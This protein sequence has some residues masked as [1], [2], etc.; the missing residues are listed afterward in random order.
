MLGHWFRLRALN[1]QN[2]NITV[3]LTARYWK[4]NSSGALVYS[5]PQTLINN[6]SA[7]MTNG[8]SVSA[9]IDNSTDLW[10]GAELTLSCT[11]AGTTNGA[12]ALSL[13]L[14]RSTD[15]GTTWPVN[16]TGTCNGEF[17]GGYTVTAADTTNARLSNHVAG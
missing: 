15:G 6:V 14:E 8:T 17:V 2:Q 7:G 11:A 16:H 13:F 12:G 5:T 4:F 3:T 9:N 1:T 10:M